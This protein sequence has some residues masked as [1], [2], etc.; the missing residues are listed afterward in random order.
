MPEDDRIAFLL[1]RVHP[2]SVRME[3]EVPRPI[4]RWGVHEGCRCRSQGRGTSHGEF[5]HVDPVLPRIRAHNPF[6]RGVR[7]HLVRVSI[8]LMGAERETPRR[9]ARGGLLGKR[10]V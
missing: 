3:S 4:S 8:I 6:I 9:R 10:M 1:D 7:L 5:P 2:N